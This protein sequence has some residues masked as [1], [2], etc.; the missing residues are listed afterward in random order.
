MKSWCC[1][2]WIFLLA[3]SFR[4]SSLACPKSCGLCLYARKSR[5]LY[6][7][8]SSWIRFKTFIYIVRAGT[9]KVLH[10]HLIHKLCFHDI[11]FLTS[12]KN[13]HTCTLHLVDFNL[14]WVCL[15]M[16]YQNFFFNN[17]GLRDILDSGWK[18]IYHPLFSFALSYLYRSGGLHLS[19]NLSCH[20][21][22][23]S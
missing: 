12:K 2:F 11:S 20:D 6:I 16:Q 8:S 17:V 23:I 22:E 18:V 1:S 14:N 15:H 19:Y 7:Y 21:V 10:T 9:T 13:C 4:L 5:D 3:V